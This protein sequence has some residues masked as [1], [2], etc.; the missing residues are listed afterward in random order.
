MDRRLV[1]VL[2]DEQIGGAASVGLPVKPLVHERVQRDQLG[3]ASLAGL[4]QTRVPGRHTLLDLFGDHPHGRGSVYRNV[5]PAYDFVVHFAASLLGVK[6][7][8]R[9]RVKSPASDAASPNG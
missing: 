1:A 5:A 3:C 2:L 9:M 4:K 6:K 7:K 8:G